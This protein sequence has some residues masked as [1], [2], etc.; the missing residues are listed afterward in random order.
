MQSLTETLIRSSFVNASR[1][2]VKDMTLPESFERMSEADWA[3]LDYYGWR[4]P[5]FANR[6]Y[7]VV[8]APDGG[9]IGAALSQT[10]SSPRSRAMCNWCRDVRLP[11]DV[12]FWAAKRAGSAGRRGASVGTLACLDFECS[13]NVRKDPPLP[14]DGYD[15]AAA[16][17][18]RIGE[19]ASRVSGFVTDLLSD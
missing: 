8:P 10:E 1:K 16:R 11:N 2:T 19:L 12:V 7:I 9:L 17:E 13:R 3:E 15:L 14:Y 18:R 5:K 4:D 6:G